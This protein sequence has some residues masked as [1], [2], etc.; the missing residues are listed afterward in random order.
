ME[1]NFNKER[2]EYKEM[3]NKK[4]FI[5]KQLESKVKILE[6]ELKNA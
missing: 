4:E 2:K 5:I 3:I 1:K 6:E